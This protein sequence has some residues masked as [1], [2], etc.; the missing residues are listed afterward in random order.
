MCSAPGNDSHH[1]SSDTQQNAAN[2][3]ASPSL[4]DEFG[5]PYGK[6]NDAE[7]PKGQAVKVLEQLRRPK[8]MNVLLTVIIAISTVAQTV[9]SCNNN[10]RTGL[11]TERLIDS[12]NRVDYAADSFSRSASGINQGVSNAVSRLQAEANATDLARQTSER[13]SREALQTTISDFRLDQRP[14]VGVE[15]VTAEPDPNTLAVTGGIVTFE[16]G[17][18]SPATRV[19]P[20]LMALLGR[21]PGLADSLNKYPTNPRCNWSSTPTGDRLALPGVPF[22]EKAS[23]GNDY[24]GHVS[25]I[26]KGTTGLY[27]VGCVDYYDP[28]FRSN[29]RTYVTEVFQPD[30]DKALGGKFRV[31][32]TGNGGN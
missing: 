15:T 22:T 19:S 1:N 2:N 23:L 20:H 16:N 31:T 8:N 14:W 3:V 4:V 32:N 5:K 29:R 13:D 24:R 10:Q 9:N 6:S 12:A 18:K 25:E 7:Q 27:L 11:Q 21:A 28:L 30:T 17:G 26:Y